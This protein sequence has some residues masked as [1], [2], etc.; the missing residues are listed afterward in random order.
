MIYISDKFDMEDIPEAFKRTER[1]L[2]LFDRILSTVI[3]I[4]GG[5][6]E[7][8]KSTGFDFEERLK[9]A[10]RPEFQNYFQI[11]KDRI[12]LTPKLQKLF[13]FVEEMSETDCYPK[14]T[15]NLQ[16]KEAIFTLIAETPVEG[17]TQQVKNGS[18]FLENDYKEI[19]KEVELLAPNWHDENS[20]KVIGFVLDSG[21]QLIAD[22]NEVSVFAQRDLQTLS[23][24]K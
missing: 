1:I 13:T 20:K 18:F 14:I 16:L 19:Q 22:V 10:D 9:K 5:I 24:S 17:L 4:Y 15:D 7:K 6:I 21:K 11:E 2:A 23:I 12:E 3:S 8:Y